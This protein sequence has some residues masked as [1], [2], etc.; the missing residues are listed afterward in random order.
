MKTAISASPKDEQLPIMETDMDERMKIALKAMLSCCAFGVC[1]HAVAA[2]DPTTTV[3]GTK[4]SERNST[5]IP[6]VVVTAERRAQPLQAIPMSI[7]AF[8]SEEL[9]RAE[10]KDLLDLQILAPGLVVTSNAGLGQIY[11]RGIGSDIVG[12]GL[13]GA[14]AVY[15]DGVYQSRPG[16]QLLKFVD[17]ARVEVMKGPQGTLYGRNATGGAINII[18]KDPSRESEGQFDAQLG[19]F[20]QKEL[21]GTLSGP[22]SP[23]VAYGR[24]SFLYNK[25]DGYTQNIKLN[26]R[27]NSNEI[28]GVRGAIEFTPTPDLGVLIN[29][30]YNDSKTTPMLKPLSPEVNPM[31][32]KYKATV[33][34]DPFTV[35]QDS[36]SRTEATQSALDAT[37]RY[38]MGWA[39]FTSVT[40][41]TSLKGNAYMDIDATEIPMLN[42]IPSPEDTK[43]WTQDFTLA[44]S[45]SGPWE[46]T[47]LAS[48]LHQNTDWNLNLALP[49]AKIVSTNYSSNTSDAYG[50]GGQ[51]SYSLGNGV[52]FTA[53]ARY[54][55]ETKKI[56]AVDKTILNGTTIATQTQDDQQTWS[57]WTP[58]FVAEYSPARGLLWFASATK[59]FKSGGYNTATI[60]P[61]IKPEYV[62]NYEAGLKSAWLNNRL[63]FNGSAFQAKYEDMQLQF[64]TKNAAGALVAVTTNAAEATSKG[65]DLEFIAK[66]T[67]RLQLSGGAQF[68]N[69]RFD[70]FLA[71]NPMNPAEGVVDRAGNPMN[72]APDST[73][74]FSAQY[75][76]PS[77]FEGKDVTLRGD[78]Y[79]RSRIYYTT[80]KDPYASEE[81]G[82]VL[83]AQLSFE[84]TGTSGFYGSVF[85]KNITDNHYTEDILASS[86]VGYISYMAPPRTFGVQIGYRY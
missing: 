27:G 84:P 35:T 32:T 76:W 38:N 24:L 50:I 9:E 56:Q 69:A 37:I 31:F 85:V 2:D 55:N 53:G 7:Q 81:L 18:S 63:I 77:A 15:V 4:A 71:G 80:F 79:K 13:E 64:T 23:G 19:S 83:N 21:R 41:T 12:A 60:S 82:T 57:A 58:K 72:R 62:T 54:S 68:L 14:V 30:R 34:N 59:G 45:S 47:A 26:Q 17:V 51:A 43:Y 33:I 86:T 1:G 75:T 11:I 40:S 46:W 70:K 20:N 73:F 49:L 6:T 29:A 28:S 48:F 10:I 44:S 65:I 39:R 5:T 67:P 22:L 61:A 25:D 8:N 52:K 3:E 42:S 66:P 78:A 36:E 74:S 16:S